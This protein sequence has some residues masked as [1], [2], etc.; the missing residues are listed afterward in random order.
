M[1]LGFLLAT[2]SV[3]LFSGFTLKPEN[4]DQPGLYGTHWKLRKLHE[5]DSVTVV[6]TRA[7]IRF[8]Q[9]KASAGGNGS[10]NSFGSSLYIKGDS[11]H[12]SRLF[13]T[14]M[15]CE[16]VQATENAFFRKLEQVNRYQV[17]GT[18]LVLYRGKVP[19]LEFSAEPDTPNP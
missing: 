17:T 2:T 6:D 12:L 3:L 11:M 8:N 7:F 5:G 13:S 10:C 18:S 9:E 4:P 16:G 19:L 1:R 14:Q 15:Y